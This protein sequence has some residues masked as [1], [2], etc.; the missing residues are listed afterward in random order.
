[1]KRDAADFLVCDCVKDFAAAAALPSAP[2]S[3][4]AKIISWEIEP[5]EDEG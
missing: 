3:G 1:M 2:E 5:P 4:A